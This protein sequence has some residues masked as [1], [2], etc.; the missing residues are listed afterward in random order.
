M[1]NIIKFREMINTLKSK[2]LSE[3][4]EQ[5][6][7]DHEGAIK[8]LSEYCHSYGMHI[9]DLEIKKSICIQMETLTI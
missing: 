1:N 6:L 9:D 2:H 4:C 5:F 3:I 8:T 7:F